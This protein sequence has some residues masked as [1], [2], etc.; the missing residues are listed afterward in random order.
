M[1]TGFQ[2]SLLP[3]TCMVEVSSCALVIHGLHFTFYCIGNFSLN[4]ESLNK[5]LFTNNRTHTSLCSQPL[6]L[7]I[8]ITS[9]KSFV[10]R[11]LRA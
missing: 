7:S 1:R 3:L 11:T 10:G 8:K 4:K 5:I 6:N 2:S 9:S